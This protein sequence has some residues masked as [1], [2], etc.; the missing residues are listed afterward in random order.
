MAELVYILCAV[1]SISCA[2]LLLRGYFRNASKLLFWSALCF[3]LLALN[4]I[5]LVV[6]L[7][8]IPEIEF[9][10]MTIRSILS[11]VAGML[12]LYGLIW[13]VT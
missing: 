7:L 4:N 9:S 3:V 5:I 13:E 12:L 2:F 6:D 10:G 8:I 11:S 1:M